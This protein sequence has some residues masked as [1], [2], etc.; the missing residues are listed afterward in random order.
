MGPQSV[1]TGVPRWLAFLRRFLAAMQPA[2]KPAGAFVADDHRTK[3]GVL[4]GSLAELTRRT[5]PDFAALAADLTEL[6]ACAAELGRSI[7]THAAS[8]TE[9][10]K[11]SRLGGDDG[12]AA[13]SLVGLRGGMDDAAR[14]LTALVGV[15]GALGQLRT[16]GDNIGRVAMILKSSGYAFA[17]ESARSK[18]CQ[19]SF[20]AFVEELRGLAEKI[21]SIGDSIGSQSRD[22]QQSLKSLT[23]AI[24]GDLEQLRRLT[25]QSEAAVRQSTEQMQG[26]LDSSHRALQ[27]AEQR[28]RQIARHAGDA[29]FHIQFGD[30]VRQRL[31]HVVSSLE[32]AA[33]A[34]GPGR[35]PAKAAL[36]LDLQLAQVEAMRAEIGDTRTQLLEAFGG[37]AGESGRLADGVRGLAGSGA[38]NDDGRNLFD[39]LKAELHRLEELQGQGRALCT[40]VNETSQR[41]IESAA[42]ISQ[43]LDEVQDINREMHL[44]ALNAIIKTALLDD[45]GRTLEVLSAHVHSVFQESSCIVR[46]TIRILEQVRASARS[47]GAPFPAWDGNRDLQGGLEQIVRVYGEFH[48]IS[49]SALALVERQNTRLEEVR[50]RLGFLSGLSAKLDEFNTGMRALQAAMPRARPVVAT[51][52]EAGLA[53]L[54]RRYTME[55]ERAVHRRVLGIPEPPRA[56]RPVTAGDESLDFSDFSAASAGGALAATAGK[57]AKGPLMA[58]NMEMF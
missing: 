31:E 15:A 54:S 56:P 52:V 11:H 34:S 21:S 55:S 27:E 8:V 58:D 41:A 17:V 14:N 50:A 22:T 12:L 37:V 48:G 19:Q 16:Q 9:T 10:L 51:E 49:T 2:A 13:R 53:P 42:N 24:K 43:H 35:D 38:S 3:L 30:I 29:V 18:R 47:P 26:L 32:D 4:S 44:Q 23:R 57:P 25:A 39:G 46:E 20:G 5:D 28:T 7:G 1:T 36:I 45:E 40:Q 6:H 33:T